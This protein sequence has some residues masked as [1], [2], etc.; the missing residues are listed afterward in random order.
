LL[1]SQYELR[2]GYT[3]NSVA[4]CREVLAGTSDQHLRTLAYVELGLAD[5]TR[6]D[7]AGARQNFAS[8][9]A[10]EPESPEAATGMGLLAFRDADFDGATGYL[11]RAVRISP[12]D[13]EYFL[14]ALSLEKS[15]HRPDAMTA[16]R[17][18]QLLSPD[19]RDMLQWSHLLLQNNK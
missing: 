14:L 17:Q 10:L 1:L 5:V 6:G 19:M 18:A 9:L 2:Y 3:D 4:L 11:Q 8:A 13:L 16:Y 7:L 15:G 12:N